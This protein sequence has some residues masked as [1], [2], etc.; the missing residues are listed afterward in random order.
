MFRMLRTLSM[1][2]HCVGSHRSLPAFDGDHLKPS[3]LDVI[4]PTPLR[5]RR[6]STQAQCEF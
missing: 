3:E 1:T 5:I 6:S 4:E 2:F